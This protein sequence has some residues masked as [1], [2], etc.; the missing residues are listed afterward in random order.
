[1]RIIFIVLPRIKSSSLKSIRVISD[2]HG[3]LRD[4]ALR[5]LVGA[6]L[7]IHAGD[8]G[9]RD[10]LTRLKEIAPVSAVRGNVDRDSWAQDLPKSRIVEI[11]DIAIYVLHNIADL[12]LDSVGTRLNAVITGHSHRPQILWKQKVLYL[13]PGS[14]GPRRFDLPVSI[15]RLVIRNGRIEPQLVELAG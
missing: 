6:D 8:I 9:D 1:M 12:D 14:A 2:T 15:A 5:E 7:I 3:L 11:D 4:S 13:N 10:I